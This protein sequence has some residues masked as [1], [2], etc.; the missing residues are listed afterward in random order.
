MQLDINWHSVLGSSLAGLAESELSDLQ[1]ALLQH[2]QRAVRIANQ[3]LI[4]TLPFDTQPVEWYPHGYLVSNETRPGGWLNYSAGDYYIQDAGSMLALALCEITP[5]QTVLDACSAPGGKATGLLEALG[6]TGALVANEV[7]KAR[8]PVLQDAL[9]N[10]GFANYAITNADVDSLCNSYFQTFDCILVDAPCTGQSML[11]KGKQTVASF[12]GAQ[13][14]H[15]SKRQQRILNAAAAMLK[16]GGRL[17]YSTCS[18]SWEENEGVVGRFQSQNPGFERVQSAALDPWQS[19]VEPGCYRLWPHR[20]PTAGA[21]AAALVKR[22]ED[23]HPRSE[24]A[25]NRKSVWE[26]IKPSS[27]ELPVEISSHYRLQKTRNTVHLF[28]DKLPPPTLSSGHAGIPIAVDKGK[29]WEPLH[30]LSRLRIAE[31]QSIPHFNVGDAEAC[32][33]VE[34]QSLRLSREIEKGWQVVSWRGRRLGWGKCSGNGVVK[35]H[36]PKSC[37][38]SVVAPNG[39]SESYG[40]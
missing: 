31:A 21:F 40:A 15:S 27:L 9:A 35:N 34:G 29:R 3:E 37:R 5:G 6:G 28:S 24:R 16:P 8:L 38:Q 7:I 12:S 18:F 17:V 36:F 2:P 22:G 39:D 10:Q 13:I 4:T 19:P 14:E 25:S 26:T 11:A 1:S 30:P 20:H 32:D 33:F 23:S